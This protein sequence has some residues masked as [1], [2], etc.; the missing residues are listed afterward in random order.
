MTPSFSRTLVVLTS[1]ALIAGAGTIAS[2]QT[3]AI[4][5]ISVSTGSSTATIIWNTDVAATGQVVYGETASYNA[6]SSLDSTLGTSHVS[7]LGGLT[8]G[9]TYHFQ[10]QSGDGDSAHAP[11][12]SADMTLTTQ[13]GSGTGTTTTSTGSS[14]PLALVGIDSV[15]TSATADGTF[16]NGWKWT[17]H[18]TV[19][20][21]ETSFALKFGDFTNGSSG[22]IPANANIR[23][24]SAQAQSTSALTATNN[25]YGGTMT[26]T[27][28]TSATTPG[29]QVDVTVEVSVPSGTPVGSYSTTF[30]ARSQ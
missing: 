12:T 30:G 5:D 17:L 29:R 22:T 9:S 23:Y 19:P 13:D 18:F 24:S 20:D 1:L 28:D 3:P 6:S 4:S 26:L 2:A 15:S 25:D 10:I 16:G 11:A 14:T 21:N 7:Y 8:A 27:G